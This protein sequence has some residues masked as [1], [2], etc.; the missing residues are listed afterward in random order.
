[1]IEVKLGVRRPPDG[2]W[3]RSLDFQQ[4]LRYASELDVAAALIDC[5]RVFL[6]ERGALVPTVMIER[7]RATADDLRDIG[8]HLIS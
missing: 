5:N 6:I 8:R 2:D 1:V 3:S 7:D 4:V